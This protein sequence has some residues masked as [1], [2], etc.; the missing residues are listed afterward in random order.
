MGRTRKNYKGGSSKCI[1]IHLGYNNAGFGNQFF[2]Y[3]AGVVAKRRT[4]HTLCMIRS[5]GN[6]HSQTNYRSLF[7]Q[8]ESVQAND[9]RQ[10]T[11]K[12]IHRGLRKFNAWSNKNIPVE[13]SDLYL[14]GDLYHHYMSIASALPTIRKDFRKVFRTDYPN[15]A[16]TVDSPSSAFVHVR[17]GD[18]LKVFKDT[19]LPGAGYYANGI[20][21]LEQIEKIRTI[22]IISDDIGWCKKH[23][24]GPNL[25]YFDEPDELKTMYLMSLCKAGAVLSPSTFSLA[26][27]ALG[28]DENENSLIVYPPKWLTD[29]SATIGLPKRWHLANI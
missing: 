8:G 5:D 2:V 12:S 10:H 28:P 4:G 11:S 6:P 3:A 19:G 21:M 23:L 20:K 29:D 1:F 16:E 27:A 26:G 25:K 14:L 15:F 17:R 24:H 22:Y 18:Y 13:D 7:S 9:P